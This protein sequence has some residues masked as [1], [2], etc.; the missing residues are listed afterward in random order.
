MDP[1]QSV[2]WIGKCDQMCTQKRISLRPDY[3]FKEDAATKSFVCTSTLGDRISVQATGTSK[4]KAK[5]MAAK[6]M[7]EKLKEL[8]E[9][10]AL[11]R[12]SKSKERPPNAEHVED[13]PIKSLAD[14]LPEEIQNKLKL[15]LT[16][17][18]LF[19]DN[20]EAS[21]STLLKICELT[22]NHLLKRL[23][24]NRKVS[25]YLDSEKLVELG[26]KEND[27][28]FNKQNNNEQD[29]VFLFVRNSTTGQN[30]NIFTGT[31]S[32][33]SAARSNAACRAVAFIQSKFGIR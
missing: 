2:N 21:E 8:K 18:H 28:S 3:N 1:E 27:A 22:D 13:S 20:C 5:S 16:E 7:Y 33:V 6:V 32:D 24:P 10:D 31:G 19:H 14:T 11:P 9:Q 4:K 30:I 26:D 29:R 23:W 15:R 25:F 12:R 17:N